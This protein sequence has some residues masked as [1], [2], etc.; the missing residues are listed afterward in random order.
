MWY[1]VGMGWSLFGWLKRGRADNG[2]SPAVL[3][4]S[5]DAAVASQEI[6][7]LDGVYR[8]LSYIQ[9]L[10]GQLSIDVWRGNEQ[11]SSPLVERPDPWASQRAWIVETVAALALH[12]NAFWQV[13]R[14]ERGGIVSLETLDPTRVGV[15]L[16][17]WRRVHYTVDGVE[18]DRR[19]IAHLRY[20]VQP[21]DPVGLGPIQA[22]RRGLEGMVRLG[23][24][25]DSLFMTGGVPSGILSTD[26]AIT[27]EMAE[28]ASREWDRKQRAGKTAVLGRG[29]TYQPVGVKP[30]DLQWL[31]S[32]KWSVV[33]IARLFG[34]PPA[35]LAVAIEGGSLTYNS[36]EGAN[37][38]VVRDM[39]MGYLS[40]IEDALT[41]LLPRGQRAR[42]N[43]DAL[44]RP[45]T[46]SR[47]Q[48]HA[49]ALSAGFLTVDEVRA[50]EGLPP[51]TKE[52]THD[53]AEA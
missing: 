37:L 41:W 28:E 53:D 7:G 19:D 42:F 33:R 48:A 38:A 46:A 35:K 4:P 44:L 13:R 50:I 15:T 49:V 47:Y 14:D 43:L 39:L 27:A 1:N 21:G 26:E 29:L 24:Y 3:P 10:A 16:D 40:P 30:A 25:A 17:A 8:A 45:D 11:I 23:Q 12:G 31:D 20:L 36:A 52:E 2:L 9:T 5:R 34:I 18:V 22:A 6:V 32:Q 51:L